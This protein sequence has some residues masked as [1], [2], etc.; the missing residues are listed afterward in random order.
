MDLRTLLEPTLLLFTL[1]VI[2]VASVGKF[3]GRVAGGRIG[4][5][6]G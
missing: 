3:L 1:A 5:P 6:D 4:G 2:A